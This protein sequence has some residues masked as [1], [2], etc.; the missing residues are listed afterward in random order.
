MLPNLNSSII[1]CFFFWRYI[2]FFFDISNTFLSG[3]KIFCER[4]FETFVNLP[5]IKSPVDVI[6]Q[7]KYQNVY[8]G[9]MYTK[10]LNIVD[11][12]CQKCYNGLILLL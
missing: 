9:Q 4:F 5:A 8:L 2:S 11:S 6:E 1:F 3:F 12:H 10:I 7:I